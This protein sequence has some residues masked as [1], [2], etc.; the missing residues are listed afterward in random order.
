MKSANRRQRKF[1]IYLLIK[2]MQCFGNLAATGPRRV[3][4]IVCRLQTLRSTHTS[5]SLYIYIYTIYM[6]MYSFADFFLWGFWF[7]VALCLDISQHLYPC[8]VTEIANYLSLDLNFACGPQNS[9]RTRHYLDQL[10][11]NFKVCL[12]SA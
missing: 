5:I 7:Y 11:N 12:L 3:S 4:R 8:L 9:C 10:Y 2:R 1:A 6:N